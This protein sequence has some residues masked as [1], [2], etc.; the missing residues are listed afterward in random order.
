MVS[1]MSFPA[2]EDDFFYQC[3]ISFPSLQ[4]LFSASEAS[5][6]WYHSIITDDSVWRERI[7][8]LTSKIGR[9]MHGETCYGTCFAVVDID[10]KYTDTKIILTARHCVY[11]EV[12]S[13]IPINDGLFFT[14][15][16]NSFGSPDVTHVATAK[17]LDLSAFRVKDPDNFISTFKFGSSISIYPSFR[18][19][20]G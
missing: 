19:F 15:G 4:F 9:V 14:F 11:S 2:L 17:N 16:N 13:T 20:L 7:I 6:L 1:I 3:H 10:K 18:I 5:I 8:S 12:T